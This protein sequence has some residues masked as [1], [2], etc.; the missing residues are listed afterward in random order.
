MHIHKLPASILVSI[1]QHWHC[2]CPGAE[3]TPG[4]LLC[5]YWL[6]PWRIKTTLG[7]NELTHWGPGDFQFS[8]ITITLMYF[9]VPKTCCCIWKKKWLFLFLHIPL[10]I[11]QHWHIWCPTAG[12]APGTS[13]GKANKGPFMPYGDTGPE[14]VKGQNTLDDLTW[15]KYTRARWVTPLR[16]GVA[17]SWCQWFLSSL[18]Q[19]MLWRRTGA[20]TSIVPMLTNH[21]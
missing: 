16:P 21:P 17:I 13:C 20:S 8:K 2:R 1:S 14:G 19:L 5:Q 7:D 15:P 4:H 12:S 10:M 6:R 11:S 18:T 9:F 3:P